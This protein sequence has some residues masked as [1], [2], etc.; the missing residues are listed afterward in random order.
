MTVT[1]AQ[2]LSQLMVNLIGE[3]KAD[4]V[5]DILIEKIK[6]NPATMKAKLSNTNLLKMV[7]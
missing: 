7:L 2:E 5:L 4:E 6:K 1:K 3:K